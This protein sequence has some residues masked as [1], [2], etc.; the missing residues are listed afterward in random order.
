MPE[1][2]L[3][4]REV[5]GIVGRLLQ[6]A[7]PDSVAVDDLPFVGLVGTAQDVEQGAFA[8]SVLG[9]KPHLLPF[10]Y[11]EA[12]VGEKC[13]VPHPSRQILYLQI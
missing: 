3:D 4:D 11:A 2:G 9:N 10:A 6:I 7:D 5:E 8:R 12:E 13:L 1:T